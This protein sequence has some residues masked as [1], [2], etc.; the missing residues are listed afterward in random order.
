MKRR[1]DNEPD[2]GHGDHWFFGKWKNDPLIEADLWQ[3]VEVRAFNKR[4]D[5]RD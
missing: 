2:M 3:S 5:N 1:R 4:I